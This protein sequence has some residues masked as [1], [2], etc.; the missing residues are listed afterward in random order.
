MTYIVIGLGNFG[1]SLAERLTRM[2]HDVIG[3]DSDINLV[4]EYKNTISSTICLNL[5]PLL[6]DES[7]VALIVLMFVGRVGLIS[8]LSCLVKPKQHLNYQY[9]SE[10]IPIN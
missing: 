2:G 4:E 7:H 10:S 1:V 3:V 5:T 6:S 8:I 9:P